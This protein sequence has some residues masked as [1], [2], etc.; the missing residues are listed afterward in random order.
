MKF[1]FLLVGLSLLLA[2]T[3][4]AST[5]SEREIRMTAAE[6]LAKPFFPSGAKI[7][8]L[9]PPS[10]DMPFWTA[11]IDSGGFLILSPDSLGLPVVGFSTTGSLFA[12]ASPD[13]ALQKMLANRAGQPPARATQTRSPSRLETQSSN[14][15]ATNAI[16]LDLLAPSRILVEPL[17][18]THWTQW[19][20]YN[21]FCPA[22]TNGLPGYGGRAPTGCVP[23]VLGQVLRYYSW[24]GTGKGTNSLNDTN[25]ICTGT[26]TAEWNQPILWQDMKDQFQPG[27]QDSPDLVNP[28]AEFLF[29]LGVAAG[30]DYEP[31]G[32]GSDVMKLA[33]TLATNLNYTIAELVQP[34]NSAYGPLVQKEISERRPVIMNINT[35][36]S[37]T[38]VADGLADDGGVKYVHINYGWA[39]Q[40]D[41]WYAGF[42]KPGTNM[43]FGSIIGTFHP[44][45]SGAFVSCEPNFM[46]LTA[47]NSLIPDQPFSVSAFGTNAVRYS[48]TSS[49][50]W[51]VVNP[52]TGD[53]AND[54][55]SHQVQI[56]ARQIPTGTNIAFIEISGG[57]TNLP[58]T[59][60]LQIY[61][62]D[63]PA[64]TQQPVGRKTS[65]P[66]SILMEIKAAAGTNYGPC[67]A[68]DPIRY[69]WFYNDEPLAGK[70]NSW[71]YSSGFGAYFC[72]ATGTGG[73]VRSQEAVI[74]AFPP[75]PSITEQPHGY[76]VDEGNAITLNV[77]ASGEEPLAYAWYHNDDQTPLADTDTLTI[78]NT[79][80]LDAGYYYVTVSNEG[81]TAYSEMAEITV[82]ERKGSR[83]QLVQIS[84]NKIKFQFDNIQ[85]AQL[86]LQT[87]TNLITW[88][89]L[90]TYKV[91]GSSFTSSINYPAGD[92]RRY[93]R[94]KE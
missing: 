21:L 85:S 41:G 86:V 64:I 4:H 22:V 54:A 52:S 51:V 56:D 82:K 87:S 78:T 90:V 83:I 60:R 32:S 65:S 8:A 55:F 71:C 23:V 46:E 30:M 72:E 37:H 73:S 58:R 29:K 38:V 53:V 19:A 93:Y 40:N 36:P 6:F 31:S 17:L 48:L 34:T 59:V 49:Q 94:L 63:P 16:I 79:T 62:S 35:F 15:L 74:K 14:I 84:G 50:P 89:T 27:C 47:T 81:G 3:L 10:P 77:V 61:K 44:N 25:G 24:P 66:S 20:P 39:G 5:L 43:W 88:S 11:G 76:L 67:A 9:E 1:R 69:Q 80:L 26:Y 70:T 12:K 75:K 45:A 7:A 28:L 33:R 68:A 2:S 13:N 18:A 92:S 57:A 42:D 91:T